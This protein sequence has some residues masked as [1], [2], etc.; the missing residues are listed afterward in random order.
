M[1]DWGSAWAARV[2]VLAV[3]AACVRGASFVC[4]VDTR[5]DAYATRLGDAE[6]TVREE[7]LAA[8]CMRRDCAGVRTSG[9]PIRYTLYSLG[10]N[11]H[12]L[13]LTSLAHDRDGNT[14]LFWAV[15]TFFCLSLFTVKQTPTT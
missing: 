10:G 12:T 9:I 6:Y 1:T 8:C 7:A 13:S 15:S 11:L 5:S 3:L 14:R 4:A 2:A